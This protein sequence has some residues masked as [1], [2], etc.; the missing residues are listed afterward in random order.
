MM[1]KPSEFVRDD[2]KATLSI[3]NAWNSR[4]NTLLVLDEAKRAFGVKMPV[5]K[6]P[7][8]GPS[9]SSPASGGFVQ[10][11]QNTQIDPRYSSV[12][13]GYPGQ[14]NPY[15]TVGPGY[16]GQVNP[17]G[18]PGPAYPG[19]QPGYPQGGYSS[20]QPTPSIYSSVQPG[21]STS[22]QSS[23]YP[24]VSTVQPGNIIPRQGS[25]PVPG[26]S[27]V[28]AS[29]NPSY[30]TNPSNPSNPSKSNGQVDPRYTSFNQIQPARNTIPSPTLEKIN[31]I[32]KKTIEDLKAEVE[33]LQKESKQLESNS[34][35]IT[36]SI[37]NFKAEL[38]CGKNKLALMRVNIENSQEWVET[39]SS[40]TMSDLN[41]EELVEYRND[42]AKQYISLFS[43]EKS[44]ESTVQVLVE[45]INKS[46]VPAKENLVVLKKLYTDLF[47]VTRLK[48]KA[49][50]VS[51]GSN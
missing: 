28:P 24:T 16:P 51:R 13:A 41:E 33:I 3:F 30:S 32:Y 37:E 5:F 7:K 45:A 23:S 34:N 46:V 19:S 29:Q 9:N 27:T 50:G 49:E 1:I 25:I 18:L 40:S 39:Y 4:L 11:S 22:K 42:A 26:Y 8:S 2:G 47:L 35:S 15:N 38:N 21:Y 17:S 20:V 12:P 31:K 10:G 48:E 14:G 43:E 6:K 36:Q 44:L